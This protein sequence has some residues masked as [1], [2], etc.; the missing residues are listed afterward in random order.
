MYASL[1][2]LRL[3]ARRYLVNVELCCWLV[4]LSQNA[5]WYRFF[6]T[7]FALLATFVPSKYFV[8]TN[9]EYHPEA[10][11]LKKSR[12]EYM[13]KIYRRK[14]LLCNFIEITLWH[15]CSPVNLLHIFRAVFLKNFSRRLLLTIIISDFQKSK[16]GNEI[17]N[18]QMT[19]FFQFQNLM[20]AAQESK[21]VLRVYL[22]YV[23][24]ITTVKI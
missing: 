1:D 4:A 3:R 18:W 17:V 23:T 21:N 5:S 8:S 22:L 11:V 13:Q 10:A 19:L 9:L 20:N 12:S 7:S 14:P 16:L 6:S 2:F 24:I 15:G